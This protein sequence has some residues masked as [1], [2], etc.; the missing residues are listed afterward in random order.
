[1]AVAVSLAPL[2]GPSES[3]RDALGLGATAFCRP[4]WVEVAQLGLAVLAVSGPVAL[5]RAARRR[6]GSWAAVLLAGVAFAALA[7]IWVSA[8]S[9]GDCGFGSE[10]AARSELLRGLAALIPS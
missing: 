1:M 9:A 10:D 5:A 3:L 4:H 6:A 8:T 2:G 7:A